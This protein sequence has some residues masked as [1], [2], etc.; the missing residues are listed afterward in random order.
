M[1]EKPQ[2][3]KEKGVI[4]NMPDFHTLF[5]TRMPM[6]GKSHGNEKARTFN[7]I[8]GFLTSKGHFIDRA[9]GDAG[10]AYCGATVRFSEDPIVFGDM[11]PLMAACCRNRI[12]SIG[13][14]I[15]MSGNYPQGGYPLCKF[16]PE[17]SCVTIMDFTNHPPCSTQVCSSES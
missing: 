14:R 9:W 16:P 15:G 5:G 7:G 17:S 1:K 3:V 8:S 13:R 10:S 6:L 4:R 12:K 2:E 11:R